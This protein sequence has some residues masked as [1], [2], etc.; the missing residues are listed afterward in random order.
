MSI[1][2]RL[3]VR[4]RLHRNGAVL[5]RSDEFW[6]E[7]VELAWALRTLQN[8]FDY[9]GGRPGGLVQGEAFGQTNWR[10]TGPAP[11]TGM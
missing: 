8:L 1:Q 5:A 3:D 2:L 10:K 4:Q 7:D 9:V 11:K 6:V